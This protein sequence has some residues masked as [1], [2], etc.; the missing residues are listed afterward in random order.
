MDK[1]S[2][3]TVNAIANVI[4]K[5]VN[6]GLIQ[7]LKS[8]ITLSKNKHEK[9]A[10]QNVIDYVKKLEKDRLSMFEKPKQESKI[11]TLND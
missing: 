7:M 10:Y 6:N 2:K 5:N 4:F 8:S 3:E 11:I 1:E 9:K